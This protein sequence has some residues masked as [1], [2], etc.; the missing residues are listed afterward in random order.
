MQ[1][2]AEAALTLCTGGIGLYPSRK[3]MHIDCGRS[4]CWTED[5]PKE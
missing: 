3:F 2:G 1:Q 4:R 5:A